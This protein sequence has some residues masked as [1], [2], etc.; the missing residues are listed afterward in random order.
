[1]SWLDKSI[2]LDPFNP[3]TQRSLI[4]QL[5]FLK[6][7]PRARAALEHYVQVFPQDAYMRQM[8]EKVPARP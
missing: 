3:F 1:M 6:Q 7:Y 4:V 5:I 2:E 8:L